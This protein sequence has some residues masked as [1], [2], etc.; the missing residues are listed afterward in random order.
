MQWTILALTGALL[1][2]GALLVRRHTE[3]R[4]LM[5]RLPASREEFATATRPVN[6]APRKLAYMPTPKERS[7]LAAHL[8]KAVDTGIPAAS[9][10]GGEDVPFSNDEVRGVLRRVID[11][12]NALNRGLDLALISFDN[13]HKTVDAYKTLKYEADAQ[14]HSVS[15]MYSSRFTAEV[16]ISPKNAMYIR[17]LTVHNSAVDTSDVA[18]GTVSLGEHERYAPFE[19]AV[20]W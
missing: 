5:R 2:L 16:D 13:V 1:V 4:V 8:A 15:R 3:K 19:P 18:A 6:D 10:A 7:P 20:V 9:I 14:V 17:A 12:V 11:R